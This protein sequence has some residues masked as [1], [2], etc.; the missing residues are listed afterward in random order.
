MPFEQ[1]TFP[2]YTVYQVAFRCNLARASFTS[3]QGAS[4]GGTICVCFGF[5]VY[6]ER[7]VNFQ[8]RIWYVDT[9]YAYWSLHSCPTMLLL[10][11]L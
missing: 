10:Y 1:L 7:L 8:S 9:H 5:E 2:P 11:A 3:R 4:V 6:G